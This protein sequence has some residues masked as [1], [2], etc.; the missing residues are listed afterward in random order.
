MNAGRG[1]DQRQQADY[2]GSQGI[3]DQQR[4]RHGNDNGLSLALGQNNLLQRQLSGQTPQTG[5][6]GQVMSNNLFAT[7]AANNQYL[8]NSALSRNVQDLQDHALRMNNYQALDNALLSGAYPLSALSQLSNLSQQQQLLNV[9]SHAQQLQAIDQ[10][11]HAQ[12]LDLATAQQSQDLQQLQYLSHTRGTNASAAGA[13][14]AALR[15]QSDSTAS[16]HQLSQR[17]RPNSYSSA[18]GLGGIG[19][20]A[21]AAGS[22]TADSF[23]AAAAASSKKRN[24]IRAPCCA[25]GMP[26]DHNFETAYFE[27]T[28]DMEHG[29]ELICSY[30]LCRNCGIKFRYCKFCKAPVAK[31]NFQKLHSHA[32][33]AANVAVA[34]SPSTQGIS[35]MGVAASAPNPALQHDIARLGGLN[36]LNLV[37]FSQ[38][39]E[40]QF[41]VSRK[42]GDTRASRDDRRRGKRA[43]VLEGG[44]PQEEATTRVV[45]TANSRAGSQSPMNED[46]A[47]RQQASNQAGS[48]ER[49]IARVDDLDAEVVTS[50]KS[51][52]AERPPTEETEKMRDWLYR[53][54]AV[55]SRTGM[56]SSS[57]EGTSV[58][59]AQ[60]IREVL[61]EKSE[62]RS[63]VND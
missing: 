40:R 53:V 25:R 9:G 56:D 8:L 35:L 22:L 42:D 12:L 5:Q 14:A 34:G 38:N 15:G 46:S 29:A 11:Q 54:I 52:L 6:T 2:P 20:R 62:R 1:G 47:A 55:S 49:A 26:V 50:W 31:R 39:Q 41:A 13:V 43:R 17:M 7:Q 48:P 36:A 63:L 16:M 37:S 61:K 19:V 24:I 3:S 58:R 30:D 59:A 51:L 27:L 33:D 32:E 57:Q 60:M 21:S 10:Q 18:A 4:D 45:T 23:L 44:V 28:P